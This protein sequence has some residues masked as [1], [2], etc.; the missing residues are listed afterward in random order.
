MW[1]FNPTKP[2]QPATIPTDTIIPL[3]FLDD[4]PVH[5][6]IVLDLTLRFDD[7]LDGEM[8]RIALVRL[9][10]LGNW[11]KLGARLRM[12]V[13]YPPTPNKRLDAD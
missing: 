5:R 4:Q 1:P 9:M 12:N 10:E 3:H 13:S 2:A 7:A 8:L 11:R 6:S